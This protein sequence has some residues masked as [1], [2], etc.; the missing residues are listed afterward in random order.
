MRPA[1]GI[2]AEIGRRGAARGRRHN[3]AALLLEL[4]RQLAQLKHELGQAGEMHVDARR[5][6]REDLGAVERQAIRQLAAIAGDGCRRL[7]V[8]RSAAVHPLEDLE[9]GVLVDPRVHRA[10]DVPARRGTS[11]VPATERSTACAGV[12]AK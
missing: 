11:T 7:H 4:L 10:D 8:E 5:R 1:D 3:L 2:V 12:I 6:S 9:P